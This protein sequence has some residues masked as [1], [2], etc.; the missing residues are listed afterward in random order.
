MS[1]DFTGFSIP[2][3]VARWANWAL[4]RTDRG[5]LAIVPADCKVGDCVA[6]LAGGSVPYIIRC[7]N[8][9]YWRSYRG[10][11]CTRLDVWRGMERGFM[12][13]HDVCL[14]S[15]HKNNLLNFA[16]FLGVNIIDSLYTTDL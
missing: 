15:S 10:C 8:G 12:S 6:L 3:L 5:F 7:H 1:F 11:L 13:I 16:I 2:A 4:G 14:T 9:G